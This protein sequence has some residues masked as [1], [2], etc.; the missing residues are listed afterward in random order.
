MPSEPDVPG[1]RLP[2][3]PAWNAVCFEE[4]AERIR[5]SGSRVRSTHRFDL[6]IVILGPEEP[7]A[8]VEAHDSDESLEGVI[9]GGM[10]R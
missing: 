3:R 7:T 10:L 8:W 9:R 4:A 6:M 5:E 1:W 2:P